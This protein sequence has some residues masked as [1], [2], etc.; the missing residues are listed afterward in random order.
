MVDAE[1]RL[2]TADSRR[3]G[4]RLP[5]LLPQSLASESSSSSSPSWLVASESASALSSQGILAG[6]ELLARRSASTGTEGESKAAMLEGPVSLEAYF[7][8]LGTVSQALEYEVDP[9]DPVDGGAVTACE[10]QTRAVLGITG[11]ST[12]AVG[13]ISVLFTGGD[14]AERSR[15]G[16]DHCT[17]GNGF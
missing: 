13:S 4:D 5:P 10:V 11:S 12:G 8:I 3:G 7:V 16:G 6:G 1:G 2:L 15:R 17:E 14:E 9:T